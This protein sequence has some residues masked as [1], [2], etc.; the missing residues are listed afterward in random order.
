MAT[1]I[2]KTEFI[3]RLLATSLH[4][5]NNEL[6]LELRNLFL[7]ET[8]GKLYKYR[9]F[10]KKG[11][12]LSNLKACSIYCSRPGDFNDPFDCKLGYDYQS[13]TNDKF[14][15]EMDRI[16]ALFEHFMLVFRGQAEIT[17]FSAAEQDTI[18]SWM[19]N[20]ILC[21][22]LKAAE[23]VPLN[24]EAI[25]AFMR[26]N[27][28][29]IADIALGAVE[30]EEL[31]GQLSITEKLI[32]T[33]MGNI[34]Q[35]QLLSLG[36]DNASLTDFVRA[37]GIDA[38][39]DQ[40]A[41]TNALCDKVLPKLHDKVEDSKIAFKKIDSLIIDKLRNSILIGCF[42]SDYKNRLMW[43]H[44]ADS[45]KGFCIEYD[46][47]SDEK[48]V[49]DMTPFPVIYSD[50]RVK[51]PLKAAFDNTPKNI[52]EATAQI[53]LSILTKDMAWQ[54]EKE[55]RLIVP[56][57]DNPNVRMPAISC[58]YLGAL[59]SDKN[60]HK[61]ISIANKLGIPVKQM[62]VDRGEFCLHAEPIGSSSHCEVEQ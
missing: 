15:T 12:S 58:I 34:S 52:D 31:R 47:S 3:K 42:A 37:N 2:E 50:K 14:G 39:A 61:I 32:P 6:Q 16:D 57:S 1:N 40:I 36:D 59:C 11:Y 7:E 38:D 13:I 26:E 17:D 56:I 5:N 49:I 24:E 33:L 51:I 10:D 60:K 41:L 23:S 22:M 35:E 18:N 30:N 20:D 8:G 9:S 45:H 46:F 54:Y 4:G 25:G 53:I 28:S 29:V 27:V 62:T 55:W 21:D 19:T 44:Y 43:S 48:S